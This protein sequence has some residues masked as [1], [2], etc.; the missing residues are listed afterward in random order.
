MKVAPIIH[1]R[2]YS[3]DFNAKFAVRP[4]C[5]VESDIQWARKNISTATSSIDTLNGERWVVIDNGKYRIAGVVG[6]LNNIYS[7]SSNLSEEYQ[8]KSKVLFTDNKKRAIYAFIGVVIDLKNNDNYSEIT[9]D[10]LWKM[11]IDTIYPIW[12]QSYQDSI[13][14]V[15]E[16]IEFNNINRSDNSDIESYKIGNRKFYESNPSIDY[17]LF[18]YYICSN[19][20]DFSFC[21]N[22]DDFNVVKD[23]KLNFS[24]ITTSY[25]NLTRLKRTD[26]ELDKNI[27]ENKD[28]LRTLEFTN[29][30]ENNLTTMGIGTEKK[31]L[32]IVMLMII[33]V[34]VLLSI[35]V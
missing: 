21:S 34:T 30:I 9:Y 8:E 26:K 7:K 33:L 23:D 31:N 20:N 13:T 4:D 27:T 28:D 35:M 24:I 1:T 5:F 6:F 15:F 3:C 10:Y 18:K 22:I 14:K 29:N 16:D 25:N 17:N 12:K 2:T 32:I 19:A 11:Y